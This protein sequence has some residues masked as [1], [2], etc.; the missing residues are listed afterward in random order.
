M[1]RDVSVCVSMFDSLALAFHSKFDGFG[2]EPRIVVVTAINPEIVSG[3]RAFAFVL[4]AIIHG[5]DVAILC[6]NI[7]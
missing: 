6:F 3:E 4:I 5:V 7:L 1:C 2:R